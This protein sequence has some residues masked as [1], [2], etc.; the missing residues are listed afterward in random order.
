[1]IIRDEDVFQYHEK[2]R[3]GK[4]EVVTSKPCLTQRDLSMAYTPGV[5]RPCLAIEKDPEA[6][7]RFTGKGNLVAVISNGTAVLGLGNIGPLAAKPVM[8]GKATL[9]KRFADVDVFDIELNTLDPEEVIRVVKALEPTF[10]GINLEDI[11]APEC[12]LIEE[13]LRREMSIPVFHDDQHGTAIISSAAL[14]NALELTGKAISD[15]RV[16]FSGAG[17]AGIACAEMYVALGVRRDHV[18]LVDTVGVVYQG[19]TEKMNDYKARFAADTT[20]RTLADALKGADVF[21]GVSAAD[22]M[23]PEMLKSMANDPI[24]FAMANPDPEIKYEVAVAARPDAIMATGRSDYPNQVNNVL[25]FPFIFRGALDVRART[26][27]DAMKL[28]AAHALANLAKEDVPESVLQAY[29]LRSLRFG[30]DYLIPKPF[31][32][33]VLLWVAPAVAQAAMASGVAR[34]S[35]P[36]IDRYREGL[37]RIMGP[38]REV[39]QLVVH[40]AQAKPAHKIVYPEGESELILR[41]ARTVADQ[42]IARPVLVGR[43]A[44]IGE[45]A[46]ALG[47]ELDDFDIIDINRA[48]NTEMYAAAL[49]GSRSRKGMTPTRALELMRDPTHYALM[50]VRERDA[51]GFVGGFE[52]PYP[53]TIRPAIQVVGLKPGVSRVSAAHL[54]VLKER[55]FFCA[56]TMVNIDPTA[57]ELAEIALL[58][59][60]LARMFDIEPRIAMLAFSSFGSVRHPISRKVADAVEIVMRKRPDIV[61]DG[62]MHLDP[63]VVADIANENYP[64][65]RIRGDAN[66]LIFPDL[67]AGNI[68]YKMIHRLARAETIGPMLMGMQA[69]V[70]VLPHGVTAAEIVAATAITVVTAEHEAFKASGGAT[71][72][73]T[74]DALT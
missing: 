39:V 28:A 66:V 22:I 54:L 21:V 46:K 15:V 52:R 20:R 5:A 47:I 61:I 63:A 26:I 19:R 10:G 43:P 11:R 49:Y 25:G 16:V 30:R 7:F 68:G 14:L 70:N 13:R 48:P 59:A 18:L 65:S 58:T 40:K 45:Q 17:A 72:R 44:V 51:S 35:I 55:V 23:T 31:D 24:V 74:V 36:D 73:E 38:S 3:P 50:M 41:A 8:E 4:L 57:E 60:D 53:E 12:F 32:P 42:Q 56:D 6:A 33:R 29:G 37:E 9:F 34:V 67:A 71:R 64:N 1:M 2:P 62:E 27:N 69:P